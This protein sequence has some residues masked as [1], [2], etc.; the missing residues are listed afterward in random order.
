MILT[1]YADIANTINEL[2]QLTSLVDKY[3]IYVK[4]LN[5]WV[6]YDI[7]SNENSFRTIIPNNNIGRWII[8]NVLINSYNTITNISALRAVSLTN[9]LITYCNPNEFNGLLGLSL[10]SSNSTIN[11]LDKGIYSD[12]FWNWNT[13]KEIYV[14]VN[15]ILTQEEPNTNYLV[16]IG[17]AVNNTT[18]EINKDI[19]QLIDF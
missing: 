13:L 17:Y 10:N 6:S 7:N 16:R 9:N 8:T 2:K 1:P 4:Q 14:N 3:T 19:C 5:S 12:N 11:V 15:G 18:I